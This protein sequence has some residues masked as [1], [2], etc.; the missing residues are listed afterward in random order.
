MK[1]KKKNVK[2]KTEKKMRWEEREELL[3]AGLK[4]PKLT[5]KKKKLECFIR[6]VKWSFGARPFLFLEITDDRFCVIICPPHA[7]KNF[8]RYITHSLRVH[9]FFL[10]FSNLHLDH[11][12]TCSV[13]AWCPLEEVAAISSPK[14]LLPFDRKSKKW[15]LDQ[16]KTPSFRQQVQKVVTGSSYFPSNVGPSSSSFLPSFSF[17]QN[18]LIS[19]VCKVAGVFDFV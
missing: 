9:K 13:P 15:S 3:K 7:L 4:G 6:K 17:V 14:R 11:A 8:C 12:L 2:K 1:K 19:I 16:A 18:C 5:K 10:S